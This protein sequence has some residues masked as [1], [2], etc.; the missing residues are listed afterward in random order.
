LW[1]VSQELIND[2]AYTKMLGTKVSEWL[3]NGRSTMLKKVNHSQ[4]NGT[5]LMYNKQIKTSIQK[6]QSA[7][8]LAMAL[9]G[10]GHLALTMAFVGRVAFLVSDCGVFYLLSNSIY[11]VR[12]IWRSQAMQRQRAKIRQPSGP[13]SI[14]SS[15]LSG[16]EPRIGQKEINS[17]ISK[18][19]AGQYC[20][21]CQFPLAHPSHTTRYFATL[22]EK[23][24]ER[25]PIGS[26]EDKAYGK[27][28]GN[29]VNIENAMEFDLSDASADPAGDL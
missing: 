1:G 7:H 10:N 13:T 17:S 26:K 27:P 4:L 14:N 2:V 18:V 20:L 21:L 3:S 28:S 11:S 6:N 15:N 16:K 8:A 25:Y 9:L 23:D 5:Q 22:L 19:F 12:H 29:Q 24:K